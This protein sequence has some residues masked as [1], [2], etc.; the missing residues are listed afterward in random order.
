[1]IINYY[2]NTCLVTSNKLQNEIKQETDCTCTCNLTSTT[3]QHY[4]EYNCYFYKH[5]TVIY[6]VSDYLII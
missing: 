6:C 1:M 2:T 4:Y 3:C 5:T